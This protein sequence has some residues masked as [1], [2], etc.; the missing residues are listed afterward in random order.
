[1]HRN[2]FTLLEMLVVVVIVAVLVAM[3]LPY[4][5]NAVE[6]ARMTEVVMLWGRQKNWVTGQNLSPEQAQRITYRLQQAKL[7]YFS[8][9]IVCREKENPN[10]LCWEAEFTQ[11]KENSHARYKLIT[12]HNFTQLACLPLNRAGDDFCTTQAL[13]E[14]APELIGGEK[15]Y[16]IR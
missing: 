4:Y 7:A 12:T 2:G 8:G 16:P 1:M 5:F 15:A 9:Q 3:A 11:L 14:N 13:D 6:S 10:E